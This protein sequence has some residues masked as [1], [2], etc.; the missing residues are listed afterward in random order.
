MLDG[1]GKVSANNEAVCDVDHIPLQQSPARCCRR[2]RTECHGL[3]VW[4]AGG[5]IEQRQTSNARDA[6]M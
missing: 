3:P 2:E 4:P 5:Q 1:M 6:V